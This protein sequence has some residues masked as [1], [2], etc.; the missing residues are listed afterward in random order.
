[1]LYPSNSPLPPSPFGEGWGEVGVR[2]LGWY[3]NHKT[4]KNSI[5]FLFLLTVTF[6]FIACD[7]TV[8]DDEMPVINMKGDG[9]PQNCV[10]VYKGESFTFKALFTDNIELGSYS[11][12]M[13]HNFD[14]HTHSTSP[15]ECDLDPIKS[16]VA[17]LYFQNQYTIPAGKT[18][19]SASQV[20]EI[21]QNVDSGDYHFMVRLTDQ[22]GWQTFEGISVIV[23][24]K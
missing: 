24:D 4:M 17:P 6:A 13:H 7:D 16:P 14:H 8:K 12:E 22:S 1:M 2:G 11:I 20:I 10:T 21:P 3:Y 15:D 5:F 9:F 19:F 23:A 18:T